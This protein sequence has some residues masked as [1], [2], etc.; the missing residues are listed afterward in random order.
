ML[1]GKFS[2]KA[3]PSLKDVI[4]AF[5]TF[6]AKRIFDRN[7][8]KQV[9]KCPNGNYCKNTDALIIPPSNTDWTNL[10]QHLVMCVGMGSIETL[11]ESYESFLAN[12]NA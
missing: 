8:E 6:Q 10:F 2:P 9:W 5:C 12:I 1:N 4:C 11:N 7:K 3:K